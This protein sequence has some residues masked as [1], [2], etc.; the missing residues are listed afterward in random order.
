MEL[1]KISCQKHNIDS[2]LLSSRCMTNYMKGCS[3]LHINESGLTCL[4][5]LWW[6]THIYCID[7]L[8]LPH[9]G[10]TSVPTTYVTENK[11][12]YYLEIY[13][14][15][16]SCSLALPFLNISNCQ[17]VLKLLSLCCKLFIFAWQLYLQIL[18]HKLPFANLLDA[19][20]YVIQYRRCSNSAVP[21]LGLHCLVW[22]RAWCRP[23]LFDTLMVFLKEVFL[24][25]HFEKKVCNNNM[26]K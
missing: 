15:Q 2:L 20:L 19:W 23:K 8:E 26:L 14:F 24:K 4:K 16:V 18:V 7:T 21:H 3:Y 11:E 10:N 13:I 25:N 12:E 5:S 22:C 1:L 6:K 9:R 17:S